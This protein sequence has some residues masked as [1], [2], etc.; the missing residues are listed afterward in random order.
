[1]YYADSYSYYRC[2]TNEKQNSLIRRFIPKGRSFD[3]VS[4]ETVA[5]IE[6]RINRL[7]GKIFN[8]RSSSDLC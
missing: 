6:D 1:M 3:G 2:G 5:A 4:D 8:Y 7:P